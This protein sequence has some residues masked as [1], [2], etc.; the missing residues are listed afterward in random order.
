MP[1]E[2]AELM[3]QSAAY[4]TTEPHWYL[5]LIAVD[6]FHRWKNVGTK[7]L[8]HGLE[9]CDRDGVPAYLESTNAANLALYQRAGFELLAKVQV[10]QSPVRY[11]MLR[12]AQK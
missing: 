11:P 9:L 6:P 3:S 7:L 10:G 4:C 1:P 8:R 5:G 2:F 12:P